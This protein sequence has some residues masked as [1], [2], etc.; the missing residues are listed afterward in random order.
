MEKILF[1]EEQRF[2]QWWRWLILLMGLSAVVVPF[3]I[4]IYSQVVLD[5]P[6]G[7]NP[8][9]T[10]GL[11][12]TGVSSVLLMFFIFLVMARVR[13]KTKITAEGLYIA[14]SPLMKKWKKITPDEIANYEIRTYRAKREFGGYGL[15]RRRRSGQAYIIS[16]NV[17]LQLYLKNGKKLLIGTEKKQAIEHAMRKLLEGEE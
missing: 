7:D 2:T 1:S 3:A 11:I 16:G 12:V 15:R 4:G 13:L 9:S 17:G 5:K 10:E 14:F 6:Y 8:M